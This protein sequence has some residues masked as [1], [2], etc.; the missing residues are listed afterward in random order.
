MHELQ[1]SQWRWKQQGREARKVETRSK[2]GMWSEN[3]TRPR[4]KSRIKGEE[5]KRHKTEYR[6]RSEITEA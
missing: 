1:S 4:Y 6:M 2:K 5:G 3:Y